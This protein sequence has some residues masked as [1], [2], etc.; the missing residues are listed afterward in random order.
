MLL[1]MLARD[2]GTLTLQILAPIKGHSF[3][4]LCIC[5]RCVPHILQM[6]GNFHKS[7][8]GVFLKMTRINDMI[9]L[10]SKLTKYA[11]AQKTVRL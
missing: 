9:P 7:K 8:H 5:S 6:H 2:F 4:E 3:S 1:T 10:N 11:S